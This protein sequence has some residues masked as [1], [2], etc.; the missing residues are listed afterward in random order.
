MP[1]VYKLTK[2]NLYLPQFLLGICMADTAEYSYHK[3]DGYRSIR[4][5]ILIVVFNI[6]FAL[7]LVIGGVIYASLVLIAN[8]LETLVNIFTLAMMVY[9]VLHLTPQPPDTEHPYGHEKFSAFS[10]IITSI[11]MVAIAVYIIL[12]A[13]YKMNIEYAIGW[14]ASFIA[15]L[16]IAPPLINYLFLRALSNKYEEAGLVAEARHQFIDF[17]DS[18]ITLI[19]VIGAVSI[20][21]IYDLL[22]ASILSI[23]IIFTAIWNI[24]DASYI[25]LDYG[26]SPTIINDI[27]N[28]VERNP[29]IKNC[30]NIRSRKVGNYYF[31]DMHIEVD[32]EYHVEDAHELVHRIE[33]EIRYKYPVIKDIIIHVEPA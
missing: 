5:S 1:D 10:A 4:L 28:I 16:S 23:L 26:L 27:R 12:T 25:L 20:S 24:R 11:A 18:I 30:H 19:G 2:R 32:P 8:G 22:A 31:L 15:P 14:E 17:L 6:V 21:Y 3:I 7:I 9:L 29:V 33:E 13:L